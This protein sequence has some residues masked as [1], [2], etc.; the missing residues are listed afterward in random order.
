MATI[1]ISSATIYLI[2]VICIFIKFSYQGKYR[3]STLNNID[4]VLYTICWPFVLLGYIVIDI[5]I[6]K[7][8]WLFFRP[9][10]KLSDYIYRMG[11]K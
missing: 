4:N 5:L 6:F 1:C 3:Y 11:Q 9:F 10:K 2:G 7:S 8:I